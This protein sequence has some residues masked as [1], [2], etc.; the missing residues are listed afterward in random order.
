MPDDNV[1]VA[2]TNSNVRSNAVCKRFLS[3]EQTTSCAITPNL[4]SCK[5]HS[6]AC[7]QSA[8]LLT[9]TRA[10]SSFNNVEMSGSCFNKKHNIVTALVFTGHRLLNTA[11]TVSWLT[12]FANKQLMLASTFD[13]MAQQTTST[14]HQ[15]IP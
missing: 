1:A 7:S 3:G 8:N 2:I 4:V 12:V 5:A 9:T 11:A 13:L 15:T 10:A 14:T 6:H